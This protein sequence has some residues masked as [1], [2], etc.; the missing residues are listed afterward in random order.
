MMSYVQSATYE[1]MN[2]GNG[3]MMLKKCKRVP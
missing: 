2:M 1:G 3:G